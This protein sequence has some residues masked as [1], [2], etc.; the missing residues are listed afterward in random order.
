MQ[1]LMRKPTTIYLVIPPYK[2]EVQRT[3]LR[4]LISAGMQSYKHYTG[5]NR[6]RCMFLID[7]F[8]ALG[9]LDEIPRDI[10]TM[11]G[12]GVD[13]A[14]IAQ[15]LDQL[16]SVYGDAA[17]TII[18]NWRAAHAPRRGRSTGAAARRARP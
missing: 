13:F 17:D 15:G 6:K 2:M 8:P 18:N 11:A 5:Q 7:E 10:A 4:L 12:Y 16:K 14:L 9:R 3:W 1:D